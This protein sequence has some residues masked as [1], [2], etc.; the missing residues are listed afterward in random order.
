MIHYILRRL[1]LL[2]LTLFCIVMLNFFI[3]NLAPGEPST[4][5][6]ISNQG[7]AQRS[8]DQAL[9]SL[10]DDPYLQFRQHYGLTLPVFFNPWPSITEEKIEKNLDRLLKF[11]EGKQ[12]FKE[13]T[14]MRILMGDQSRYLM[15]KLLNIAQK[16]QHSLEKR[17]LTL[18]FFLRAGTRRGISGAMLSKSEK[19]LN[20]EIVQDNAFLR[21][22]ILKKTLSKEEMDRKTQML[23][24]WLESRPS[25]EIESKWKTFFFETR[26]CRYISR[27][28]QLDFGYLRNDP[29]KSVTKEVIKRFKYSLSLAVFPMLITFFLCQI[30]AA[31]MA[32]NKNKWLDISLNLVFLVL[33]ATPVFVVAP[34]LIEKVALHNNFP[35]SNTPI[36]LNGFSSFNDEYEKMTSLGRLFDILSHLALPLISLTYASLA[37]QTRLSR[38]AILEVIEQDYIRTAR[39][40]GLGTFSLLVKHVGRNAAIPVVTSL[41]GSLGVILGGSLIVETI[42]E[43]NGFGRFFYDAVINRDY[44]VIMFST[45]A[46]SFLTLLGYLLADLSYAFLD[47]RITLN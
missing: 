17:D 35:F 38:N 23:R 45:L 34:L 27:V 31:I 12:K 33:Y 28:V 1:L 20:E 39:A 47:P 8:E 24:E 4:L 14:R 36:P 41:A 25:F 13:Y 29:N 15:P 37:A 26:F 30:F 6:E 9:S 44:N 22:L 3:I 46:G 10:G 2:P 42:F 7:D 32:L 18:R 40:K 43:I 5:S 11:S 16:E 21:R 19:K